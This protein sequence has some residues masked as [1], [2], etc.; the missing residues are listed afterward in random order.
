MP[1]MT[2]I[3]FVSKLRQMKEYRNCPVII[4]SSEPKEN[5]TSEIQTNKISAYIQKNLFKQEEL[6]S[7]IEKLLK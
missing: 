3:E 6:I 5:Y 7:T 4:V 1:D 2:G